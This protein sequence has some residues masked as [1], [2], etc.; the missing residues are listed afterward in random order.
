MSCFNYYPT[1][2][3]RD[4]KMLDEIYVTKNKY[5]DKFN[6]VRTLLYPLMGDSILLSESSE[7]WSNKRKALSH[8]FYKDKLIS[9]LETVK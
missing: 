2:I 9:M 1:L 3:V 5:F 7:T 8:A 6:T 4:P